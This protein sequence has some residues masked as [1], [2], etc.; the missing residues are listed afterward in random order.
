MDITR[1]MDEYLHCRDFLPALMEKL[2]EVEESEE[3]A[4]FTAPKSLMMLLLTWTCH[5][6]QEKIDE[7]EPE[8]FGGDSGE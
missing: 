4:E 8:L 5:V 6:Y 3:G 1:K 7:L 2:E